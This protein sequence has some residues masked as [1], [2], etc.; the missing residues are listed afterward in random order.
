MT[1][2]VVLYG[3][4]TGFN[5]FQ[6]GFQTAP[7]TAYQTGNRRFQRF[8]RG[9]QGGF[10]PRGGSVSFFPA[11]GQRQQTP[12]RQTQAGIFQ[13]INTMGPQQQQEFLAA[14][15]RAYPAQQQTANPNVLA[16]M[17]PSYPAVKVQ[18]P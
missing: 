4:A 15:G 18:N 10:Q 11:V 2:E 3:E 17:P 5:N 6:T 9:G 8:R 13:T 12:Y 7:Q 14:L 1:E 16:L